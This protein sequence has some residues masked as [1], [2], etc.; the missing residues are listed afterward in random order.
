[1]PVPKPARTSETQWNERSLQKNKE[2]C[3]EFTAD[4]HQDFEGDG[5][6]HLLLFQATK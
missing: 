1:M 5:L 3:Y 2:D 6:L 4:V